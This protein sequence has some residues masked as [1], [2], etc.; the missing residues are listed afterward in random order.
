MQ[1]KTCLP[2]LALLL[3][4]VTT[5]T[6]VVSAQNLIV[7]PMGA[8]GTG[9]T[10]QVTAE[11]IPSA[12]SNLQA[13]AISANQINITWNDNSSDETS[14]RLELRTASGTYADVGTAIPANVTGAQIHGLAPSTTYFF[15]IKSRNAS[16]DSGYSNEASAT[17][18]ASTSSCVESPTA[19]CLNQGRFRVEASYR[20]SQGQSGQAHA[21][22]LVEDSGYLWF[23]N[24]N[25]IEVVVKVLNACTVNNRYW[26]FAGGLTDVEVQ[27]I[28][29]DTQTGVQ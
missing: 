10:R 21:V 2:V 25:N 14:F 20:T 23:F 24:P 27:L 7:V 13:F 11:A 19:I 22:Q 8:A 17:T 28:V 16:G 6:S 4:G 26:I 15:R 29:T 5:S 18:L 3:L 9:P 12:P 1:A